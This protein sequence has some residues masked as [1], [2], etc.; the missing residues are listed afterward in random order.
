MG[1]NL[2]LQVVWYWSKADCLFFNVFLFSYRST[3]KHVLWIVIFLPLFF[4]NFHIVVVVTSFIF[5]IC[6][7]IHI[8]QV[9]VEFIWF[10]YTSFLNLCCSG[11]KIFSTFIGFLKSKDA[12]DGT[13]QALL[14]ELSALNDYIKTNVRFHLL[15]SVINCI[16]S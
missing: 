8:Y 9:K 6:L 13:E 15:F 5:N 10:N 11:S 3:L 2:L 4:V 1:I 14:N 7:Y 16:C 12:S